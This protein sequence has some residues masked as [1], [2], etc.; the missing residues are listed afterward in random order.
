MQK[1]ID[2]LKAEKSAN[3]KRTAANLRGD[4]EYPTHEVQPLVD[5]RRPSVAELAALWT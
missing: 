5:Q 3:E 1:I 2:K 4:H